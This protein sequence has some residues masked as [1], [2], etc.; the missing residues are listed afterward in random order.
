MKT[1]VPTSCIAVAGQSLR[2]WRKLYRNKIKMFGKS[3]TEHI[4][5]FIPV[6]LSWS[7]RDLKN[8]QKKDPYEIRVYKNDKGVVI[9]VVEVEPQNF[10]H[11]D[12]SPHINK[13]SLGN[14]EHWAVRGWQ[15]TTWI[16]W[17]KEWQRSYSDVRFLLSFEKTRQ[18]FIKEATKNQVTW[19]LYPSKEVKKAVWEAIDKAESGQGRLSIGAYSGPASLSIEELKTLGVRVCH[20]PPTKKFPDVAPGDHVVENFNWGTKTPE[21][22]KWF[23]YGAGYSYHGT[24][25]CNSG[26][27]WYEG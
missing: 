15:E 21:N 20:R 9:W 8:Y 11:N 23:K 27:V 18:D 2:Q 7:E 16:G 5:E 14:P 1:I 25:G 10:R 26:W 4:Y 17:K 24:V 12:M 6:G 13:T 22:A 19:L 3:W